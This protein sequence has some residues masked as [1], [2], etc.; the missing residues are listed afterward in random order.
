MNKLTALFVAI[1][2]MLVSFSG[3]I[4]GGAGPPSVLGEIA[5]D[6]GH[7][8][9]CLV[10]IQEGDAFVPYYVITNDYQGCCLLLRRDVLANARRINEYRSFYENSE[11]DVF[12]NSEFLSSLQLPE[13]SVVSTNIT[14]A[15]E[16]S[17]GFS[18][19]STKEICRKVFLLSLTEIGVDDSV[20]A[21]AE[22]RPLGFF[23]DS[24]SRIAYLGGS[25]ASWWLRSPNTY[26][27]SCVYAVGR[28]GKIGY[29]NASDKN[30]VRPAFCLPGSTSI[31]LSSA[32]VSG[33][34]VYT[35]TNNK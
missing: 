20:N 14:I 35:I 15:D 1:S 6:S 12:L 4:I 19:I 22:G 28:N 34:A 3:C 9:D 26:Y 33:H 18:G 23:A 16:A 27:D 31:I 25:P 24:D 21:G 8:S 2:T 32:V 7:N 5:F 11:I 10:Y 29:G 13:E 17:L 30:G